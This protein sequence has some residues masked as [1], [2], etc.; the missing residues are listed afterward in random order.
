M[1]GL[2]FLVNVD[3]KTCHLSSAAHTQKIQAKLYKSVK[4]SMVSLK[5]YWKVNGE[6]FSL[7]KN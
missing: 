4:V 2:G 7:T 5:T 3:E 6:I 1:H